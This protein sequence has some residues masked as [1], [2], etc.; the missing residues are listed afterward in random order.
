MVGAEKIEKAEERQKI[1]EPDKY[2]IGLI[3]NTLSLKRNTLSLLEIFEKFV[4][5][6][7]LSRHRPLGP[8]NL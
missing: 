6:R 3:V 2:W 5:I 7:L 1:S 8:F 4:V